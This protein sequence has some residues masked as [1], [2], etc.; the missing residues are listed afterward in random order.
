MIVKI[1][2][3]GAEFYAF[4]GF[5]SE[6]N[7]MGH[8]FIVN[9]VVSYRHYKM[10]SDE[11]ALTVNYE[12]IYNICREEMSNT[13]KL[14]ET[15]IFNIGHRIKTLSPNIKK[16]KVSIRKMGVQLGGKVHCTLV[17]AVL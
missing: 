15:V 2:V 17:E 12:N 16:T 5:Y 3:I 6:E 14:L 13:Q 8:T 10:D 9:A 7:Q 4:H 11:L 1:G